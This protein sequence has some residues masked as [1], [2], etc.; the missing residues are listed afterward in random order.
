MPGGCGHGSRHGRFARC[1]LPLHTEQR[2]RG[3]ACEGCA[4]PS[5]GRLVA[6][7]DEPSSAEPWGR[8]RMRDAVTSA[9]PLICGETSSGAME[10]ATSCVSIKPADGTGPSSAP[11]A[12]EPSRTTCGFAF[13]PVPC[14]DAAAHITAHEMDEGAAGLEV[15]APPPLAT[16]ALRELHEVPELLPVQ[17]PSGGRIVRGPEKWY[18]PAGTVNGRPDSMARFQGP[19]S[20]A[21]PSAH[22]PKMSTRS[23]GHDTASAEEMSGEA[24]RPR[25]A[26]EPVLAGAPSRASLRNYSVV[27]LIACA[28]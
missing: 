9:P 20:S 14:R 6:A 23:S 27:W 1:F 10:A 3:S 15:A 21:L 8:V 17:K 13:R 12:V 18:V 22:A 24:I 4:T 28:L 7:A 19:R 16:M 2:K 11:W 26:T 5:A 25:P